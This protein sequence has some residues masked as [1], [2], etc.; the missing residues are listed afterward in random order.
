MPYSVL[1][2]G[3]FYTALTS[4]WLTSFI[5]AKPSLSDEITSMMSI[6]GAVGI[7]MAVHYDP[8]SFGTFT[9]PI[10]CGLILIIVSW[11]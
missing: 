11:V 9:V 5:V 10:A 1:Q 4:V 8:T 6:A 7:A 2:F 3:D